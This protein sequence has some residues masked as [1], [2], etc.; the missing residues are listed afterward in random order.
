MSEKKD[1]PKDL[2]V[3]AAGALA[4]VAHAPV[5]IAASAGTLAAVVWNAVGR[6]AQRRAERLFECMRDSDEEPGTFAARLQ[7]RVDDNDETAL[8]AFQ[9]LLAAAV[10]SPSPDAIPAI[11]YIGRRFFRSECS[12]R[13]ARACLEALRELD[14]L[15]L[16]IL[17][18]F[19]SDVRG[20]HSPWITA[21]TA[22]G[23][24]PDGG[25]I[26]WYATVSGVPAN[27]TVPIRP[28]QDHR[29]LFGCLKRAGVGQESGGT[30]VQ[31][32]QVIELER[33]SIV[34]LGEALAEALDQP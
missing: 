23:V 17:R 5:L 25:V 33:A 29:R 11:G 10:Q 14:A 4:A 34:L 7:Q 30:D 27:S 6:G 24:R 31:P 3:G 2:A 20:V 13:I 28:I 32:W 16:R 18:D 15:E 12:L 22:I 8:L 9:S 21:V 19:A 26:G 1:T